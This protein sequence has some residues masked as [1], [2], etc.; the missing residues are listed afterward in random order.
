[1]PADFIVNQQM[2]STP[3]NAYVQG[4]HYAGTLAPQMALTAPQAVSTGS[5]VILVPPGTSVVRISAAAATT[6]A[7]LPLGTVNGQMLCI[8]I[9]TAA[10]NTVT[11]AA[12]GTSNCAGGTTYVLSGLEAHW[13]TWDAVG[14][15]WYITGPAA[16]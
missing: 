4:V 10:L 9:T 14:A 11:M 3:G 7:S 13:F 1:M 12:S 8:I 16:N 6:G 15:L 5:A 2:I